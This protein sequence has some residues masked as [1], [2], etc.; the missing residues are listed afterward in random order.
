MRLNE[1]QLFAL[2]NDITNI[3]VVCGIRISKMFVMRLSGKSFRLVGDEF[4]ISGNRVMQIMRRSIRLAKKESDKL[5]CN[6]CVS[7]EFNLY[8]S[9]YNKAA[10]RKF[11]FDNNKALT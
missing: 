9:G 3:R 4:G 7:F 2:E 8:L 6:G 11:L 5:R 10:V 1:C